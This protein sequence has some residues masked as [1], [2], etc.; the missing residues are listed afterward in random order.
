MPE[1]TA[2][3]WWGRLWEAGEMSA[4]TYDE[5]ALALDP[6]AWWDYVDGAFL[7][8]SGHG[9]AM[10]PSGNVTAGPS[11]LPTGEG[12]SA[13]FGTSANASAPLPALG[14][15]WTWTCFA[16]ASNS[17]NGTYLMQWQALGNAANLWL[18]LP[19]GGIRWVYPTLL[20]SSVPP[21]DGTPH[22]FVVVASGAALELEVDGVSIGSTPT[23]ANLQA[24]N[25]LVGGQ[26][27]GGGAWIRMAKVGVWSR[28]LTPQERAAL[29]AAR[30]V[31]PSPPTAPRD[32]VAVPAP[33]V[34]TTAWQEP[35]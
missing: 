26:T 21:L 12:G 28:A 27:A 25:L 10:S 9:R 7:D 20:T 35:A 4:L 5:Q 11:L 15:Q 23:V 32:L 1:V 6:L 31:V 33:R 14:Q 22:Q 13:Q 30:D 8:A 16:A 2:R 18:G 3:P 24:S 34:I 19:P 17:N 29:W